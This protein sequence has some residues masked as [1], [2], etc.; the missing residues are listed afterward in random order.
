MGATFPN[1]IASFTQHR[2]QY[3]DVSA[4][5]INKI[6]AEVVAIEET[7]GDALNTLTIIES[8]IVV[9]Q[10]EIDSEEAQILSDEAADQQRDKALTKRFNN[11]KELVSALWEG[12]N[13]YAASTSVSNKKLV[14]TAK[15]RPYPPE[16]VN[17][18]KPDSN[19]DP[20]GMWN[21]TGFTLPKSGFWIAHGHIDINLAAIGPKNDDN[22][23]TYEASITINGNEWTR[24]LDRRYPVVDKTWHDVMLTPTL[25]GWFPKG[26]RLTLRA[27]QSS[28]LNQNIN[29]G[30]LAV[31]RVRGR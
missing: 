22:F 12:Q 14:K 11:L 21:G 7:L 24:A 19:N 20:M 13:I 3:D 6:Q 2:D 4:A 25:A 15:D 1:G 30:H 16:L 26:T 8:E 18:S 29:G 5:D 23:G 10:T 27:A 17:L 28:S 31:Y 9:L